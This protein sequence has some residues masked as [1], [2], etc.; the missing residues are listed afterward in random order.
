MTNDD[1]GQAAITMLMLAAVV[2]VALSSATVVLGGQVIDR[3]RARTAADAAALAGLEGGRRAAAS[4]AQR[5][6][7]ELVSFVPG[8]GE[9]HVTV[10]VQVGDRTARARAT[11]G[12]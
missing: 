6:G 10:V 3:T 11:D 2:F 4:L 8:P 9:H 7:A 5:H 1:R 12:P